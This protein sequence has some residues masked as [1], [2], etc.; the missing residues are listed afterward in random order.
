MFFAGPLFG[1]NEMQG[2]A[3]TLQ[4]QTHACLSSHDRSH[5]KTRLV[6]SRKHLQDKGRLPIRTGREAMMPQFELPLRKTAGLAFNSYYSIY[7]FVDHDPTVSGGQY[8]PTNLDY[9][10]GNRSY[11]NADGYNHQGIDYVSWPFPWHLYEHNFVEVIAAESGT[12]IGKDDGQTDDRCTP[13]STWNA[14]YLQH[15][16][17]SES[18]Y[19]HLKNNSLT[20]KTVG[21]TVSKGE[22]LGVVASSGLSNIPHLHFEVYDA[23]N[24]LI[25]PYAGACNSLNSNTSWWA[26][27][28][29]YREPTL[30]TLLTHSAVPIHGCPTAGEDPRFANVFSP[31][32]TIFVA[33]YYRDQL[34]DDVT[35]HRIRRPDNSVWYTW[36]HTAPETYN[37]S[38]WWSSYNLPSSGPFGE[39]TF[40]ATYRGQTQSHTFQYLDLNCA[41]SGTNVWVGPV[42]G[43]W[44]GSNS[45]WSKEDIP[46][47]CHEV[48]I[49]AGHTVNVPAGATARC[50]TLEVEEGAIL[51]VNPNAELQVQNP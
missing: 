46:E 5:I 47:P 3:V 34:E 49:P 42:S 31:G 22:Y 48:Y 35:T 18:W 17:G 28:P 19:G 29:A 16:D 37:A 24:Q 6:E 36:Q 13:D 9:N 23:S 40:E 39:W 11:D 26:N 7:N 15:A 27:Q 21:Q 12:I 2:G 44:T 1:Q 32:Q 4:S 38:F 50:Y 33:T 51:C 41:G 10:C 8:G 25:D 30:N 45:Y 14:V 43:D 20:T